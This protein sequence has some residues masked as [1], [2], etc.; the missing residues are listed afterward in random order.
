[1]SYRVVVSWTANFDLLKRNILQI[2]QQKHPFT[3]L[4][5]AKILQLEIF[6]QPVEI[7]STQASP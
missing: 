3:F 4:I 5:L 2:V 7:Q 1:M 6:A